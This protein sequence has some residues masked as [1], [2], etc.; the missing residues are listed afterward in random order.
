MTI[1]PWSNNSMAASFPIPALALVINIIF[2]VMSFLIGLAGPFHIHLIKHNKR[3]I[4][5]IIAIM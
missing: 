2:T 4:P 3:I 1:T 5:T